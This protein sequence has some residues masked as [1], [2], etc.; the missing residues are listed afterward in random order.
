MNVKVSSAAAIF[1][2]LA[3]WTSPKPGAAQTASLSKAKAEAEA[4]GY[5]FETSHDAIVAKAKKEGKV[6]VFSSQ[7][8][9]A[10]RA[11]AEA[12]RKKYPFIDVKATEIA[13]TDTYKRM[14]QELA[15][16]KT[17]EWDVNYVAFDFYNDYLPH[18][19]KFDILGMAKHGVLRIPVE[20]IDPVNRHI[21]VLQTNIGVLA[22]N[23][24]LVSENTLPATFED[25]LKPEYKGRK[26][27]TDIRPRAIAALVPAWGLE[28][29]V[30]YAKRLAAQEPIWNRGDSRT[31]PQMVGGE[32]PMTL[33]M[34]YKS[35][36]RFKPKDV[37]DVLGAKILEPVPVRLTE[38]EG[39]SATAQNPYAGLLWLEFQASPEGQAILDKVD[40]AASHLTPGT[41]HEKATRGKKLSVLGWEH[42]PKMGKYEEE[43][44][45]AYGFPR[46]DK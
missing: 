32:V 5:I 44:V 37:Q 46:A 1:L 14:V 10:I 35:F 33:G 20:M 13:G 7:D 27:S 9:A 6:V 12:F 40:L 16:G 25:M 43:I 41:F 38:A 2:C 11:T 22:Y 39:V 29:V 21:V 18:Q 4:K 26:F 30:A 15:L 19:K 42:Y 34:N 24:K 45:K 17:T 31:L 3:A 8:D 23:K 28:K 36:L